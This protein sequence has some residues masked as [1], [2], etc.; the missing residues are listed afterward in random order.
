MGGLAGCRPYSVSS[1][2][3]VVSWSNIT[4]EVGTLPSAISVYEGHDEE[5]PL[6]A[7]YARVNLSSTSVD[8]RVVVSNQEDGKATTSN[9]SASSG[10]CLSVNAGYFSIQDDRAQHIGLLVTDEKV[11]RSATSGIFR[12]NTRYEVARSAFGISQDGSVA[13]RWVTSH[14]DSVFAWS[15][16]PRS[17]LT[18]ESVVLEM[19]DAVYW[20]VHY[21]VAGGPSLIHDGS[22]RI[23]S[24]EELFSSSPIPNVHPRTAVGITDD[25]YLILLVVDGRQSA[26][27]GINLTDLAEILLN[28]GVDSALN[29]DG[30]GSSSFV[31]NGQL[32]NKPVGGTSE[33]EIVSAISVICRN[34]P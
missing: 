9:L 33:R 10:A 17:A 27:R 2:R 11:V 13:I 30:G 6:T 23:T 14:G 12:E 19:D 16:P 24:E 1:G 7:W 4:P 32:I 3:P 8:V 25:G 18:L 5:T 21:A 22:V 29:L 15:E 20:P 34:V 28:L 26:S 31:V